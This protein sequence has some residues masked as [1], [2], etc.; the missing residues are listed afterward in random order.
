MV[1]ALTVLLFQN[2]G[3]YGANKIQTIC[4]WRFMYTEAS[5]YLGLMNMFAVHVPHS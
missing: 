2:P 5:L 1:P 4:S 3:P